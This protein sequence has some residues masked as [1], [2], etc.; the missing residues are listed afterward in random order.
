MTNEQEQSVPRKD[1]PVPEKL[2][3]EER[4]RN[5]KAILGDDAE[6]YFVTP[7]VSLVGSS[8]TETPSSGVGKLLGYTVVLFVLVI[9]GTLFVV[10]T[11]ATTEITVP[12]PVEVLPSAPGMTAP[13][14]SEM[15]ELP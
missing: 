11:T 15:A 3:E 10:N 4:Y 9:V 13:E 6:K 14:T 1:L 8:R 12:P 2:S 5:M 7:D